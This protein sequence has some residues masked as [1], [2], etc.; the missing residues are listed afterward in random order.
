MPAAVAGP[1]PAG[2]PVPAGIASL[3]GHHPV[4]LVWQNELG[5][6]AARIDRPSG[7]VFAKWDPAGSPA[8][9]PDEAERMLWLAMAGMPVPAV[10]ELRREPARDL[11]VTEAID[12]VS[13]V[14]AEGLRDPELA[15]AALGEGLRR[16]HRLAIDDCPYPAPRWAASKPVDDPVVCH[17]DPCA[18]NTLIARGRR[19]RRCRAG[20]LGCVRRAPRRTASGP[21]ACA[22]GAADRPGMTKGPRIAPEPF[23]RTNEKR[24]PR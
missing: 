10:V 16:L 21:V 8:S 13:V 12:A 6:I 1:S 5:G 22:V 4:E 23:G 3:A 20:V 19:P 24:G 2:T 17:G 11:L 18:P 9:L 14:S 7:P 15:A